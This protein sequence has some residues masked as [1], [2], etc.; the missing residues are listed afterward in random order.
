MREVTQKG[1]LLRCNFNFKLLRLLV[2]NFVSISH[3]DKSKELVQYFNCNT[4]QRKVSYCWV[5][6]NCIKVLW[7]FLFQRVHFWKSIIAQTNCTLKEFRKL[8]LCV[9]LVC[10]LWICQSELD[11]RMMSKA[12]LRE[13]LINHQITPEFYVLVFQVAT[14]TLLQSLNCITWNILSIEKI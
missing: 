1:N 6:Q 5:L 8:N 14:K 11:C 7:R 10:L 3:F 4:D 2:L 12:A 13:L 9:C